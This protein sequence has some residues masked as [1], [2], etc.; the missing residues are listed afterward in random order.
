MTI[1]WKRFFM[2]PDKSPQIPMLEVAATVTQEPHHL[3]EFVKEESIGIVAGLKHVDALKFDV[4]S[5]AELIR[6]EA[7]NGYRSPFKGNGALPPHRQYYY[8]TVGARKKWRDFRA[9]RVKQD[10]QL[11]FTMGGSDSETAPN[12]THAISR[13]DH[14]AIF[15]YC[16]K[17]LR[18]QSALLF[19]KVLTNMDLNELALKHRLFLGGSNQGSNLPNMRGSGINL[20]GGSR[21]VTRGTGGFLSR[22]LIALGGMT[23]FNISSEVAVD[24]STNN[25]KTTG[26]STLM[27]EVQNR[28]KPFAFLDIGYLASEVKACREALKL[29]CG[30]STGECVTVRACHGHHIIR[31]WG[32]FQRY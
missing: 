11:S 17:N 22:R 27:E 14:N 13:L 20:V 26:E 31:L 9:G 7:I 21:L 1:L 18:F 6:D 10:S 5:S 15:S 25:E 32:S 24:L 23:R 30:A 19:S 12:K 4:Q 3:T 8:W 29:D 2:S 28:L 16:W